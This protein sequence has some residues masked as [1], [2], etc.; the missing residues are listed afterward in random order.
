M[1][2]ALDHVTRLTDDVVRSADLDTV[3]RNIS[4]H[5]LDLL[6]ELL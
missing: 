4:N 1:S 3:R 6:K 2:V 5:V